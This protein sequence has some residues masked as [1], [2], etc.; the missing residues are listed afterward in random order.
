MKDLRD[1]KDLT[2]HD[3][4]SSAAGCG[5]FAA[6]AAPSDTLRAGAAQA[7][8]YKD[9]EIRNRALISKFLPLIAPK[10]HELGLGIP[11]CGIPTRSI[12]Y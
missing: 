3:V 4:Q 6:R 11:E 10:N 5:V 1:R 7:T 2:I 8:S 9:S 12:L